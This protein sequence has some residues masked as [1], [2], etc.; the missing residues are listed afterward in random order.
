[1]ASA[2]TRGERWSLS[3]LERDRCFW[4]RSSERRKGVEE[5]EGDDKE[6]EEAVASE[7]SKRLSSNDGDEDEDAA[8]ESSAATRDSSS[9]EVEEESAAATSASAASEEEEKE[10]EAAAATPALSSFSSFPLPFPDFEAKSSRAPAEEALR[11]A[12]QAAATACEGR[13]VDASRLRSMTR[14]SDDEEDEEDESSLETTCSVASGEEDETSLFAEEPI[15]DD[16]RVVRL[17][18]FK[19]LDVGIGFDV[20]GSCGCVCEFNLVVDF[21]FEVRVFL[22]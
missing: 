19:K 3:S 15:E 10:A 5:G 11:R 13:A 4:R 14:E 1:M 20:G 16:R 12:A 9:T 17:K 7:E 21:D 2:R 6:E 22:G 8:A 18:C